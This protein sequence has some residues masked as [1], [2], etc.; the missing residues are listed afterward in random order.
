MQ[1]FKEAGVPDGV[2]NTVNGAGGEIVNELID[3]TDVQAVTFVGSTPIARIVSNRCK[4]INKRCI[5]LGGA[6]N[7]L[8][9]LGDCDFSGTVKDVVASAF[10]CAGQR[11]MAA[12]VLVVVGDQLE[13]M[14]KLKEEVDK[15]KLGTGGG[16]WDLSLRLKA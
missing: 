11:C 13:L 8:V 1:L 16:R 3:H 12:S 14:D 10:G 9:A 7:H 15:I 2:F 4:G 5:A 6:K